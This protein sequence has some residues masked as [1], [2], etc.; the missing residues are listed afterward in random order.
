MMAVLGSRLPHW[1]QVV[2]A[3]REDV[4]AVAGELDS[5]WENKGIAG[6]PDMMV[7]MI[8]AMRL[9]GI[10]LVT[11]TLHLTSAVSR[12][13]QMSDE[14]MSSMYVDWNDDGFSPP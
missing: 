9:L 14:R 13:K 10:D 2:D 5:T 7:Q 3:H 12:A 8:S 4:E 1:Q 11:E 6:F